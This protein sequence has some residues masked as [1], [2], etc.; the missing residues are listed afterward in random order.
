[1]RC[2]SSKKPG[3]NKLQ[4]QRHSETN[5]KETEKNLL[6]QNKTRLGV[7]KSDNRKEI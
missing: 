4:K 1:M 7:E 6:P 5:Q 2:D 3:G